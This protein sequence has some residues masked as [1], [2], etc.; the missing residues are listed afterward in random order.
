[1]VMGRVKGTPAAAIT[2]M[3]DSRESVTTSSGRTMP[4]RLRKSSINSSPITP[5]ASERNTAR[6]RLMASLKKASNTGP[7]PRRRGKS[8]PSNSAITR[9]T[10]ASTAAFSSA[11][12]TRRT[13]C[14]C[15]GPKPASSASVSSPGEK[16][17]AS[18]STATVRPSAE[19]R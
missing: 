5:N 7:P 19:M 3:V 1:M 4:D 8:G 6:S 2:P 11:P 18:I 13:L 10:P 14:S 16:A 9:R 12:S 17:R 15:S